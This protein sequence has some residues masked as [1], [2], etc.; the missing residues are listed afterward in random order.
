MGGRQTLGIVAAMCV[1]GTA[2]G[3][4]AALVDDTFTEA[5]WAL[6]ETLSPLP[7]VPADPTNAVADDAD[8]A[9]LGQMFFFETSHAGAIVTGDDGTNG[10]LGSV[11]E[12][13]KVSCASCHVPGAWFHDARSNPNATS[14]AVDW[15]GRNTP[16][17]VNAAF[18]TWFKWEGGSDTMWHQALGTTEAAKSHASSR[19]AVAHMIYDKYRT[20]YEAI[21]GAMPDLSDT[22]RFPLTGKPKASDSDPDGAWEGMTTTDQDATNAILANFAKSIAAYQRLLVSRNAPFDQ[23]VAGEFTAIN[24]AAKRGLRLFIGKAGCVECHRT[25]LF[26]DNAF[27]NLGVPQTGEHV[28]T[29]DT[30]RYDA[31]AK[32]LSSTFNSAGAY[33]DVPSTRLDN[34]S[35]SED[36]RGQ[37]RTKHLR[38]IA[39]TGPYMHTGQFAT[40]TEVVEFYNMGGGSSGFD[41]TKDALLVPLN[42]TS[43]EIA[44]I[45]AFLETLTGDAIAAALMQDTS[46]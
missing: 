30:G 43:T 3:D 18:Y 34:L 29:S 10:G 21:F 46:R 8:A 9:S 24:A 2:C 7:S 23:Y 4:D 5:E 31:V 16:P 14:L 36:M 26:S 41:G 33:A 17:V 20:E 22:G 1:L 15:G 27:H 6:I 40:L 44:D 45:V 38:Q 13:G 42:L 25:P 35:Q 39:M 11:G 12:A 19:L 37:F 32:L 28:S